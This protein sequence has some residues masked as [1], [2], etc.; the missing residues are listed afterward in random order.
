[1]LTNLSDLFC[2][3]DEI[4]W[5]SAPGW[6]RELLALGKRKH[7]HVY[8]TLCLDRGLFSSWSLLRS[9]LRELLNTLEALPQL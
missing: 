3:V 9:Y 1:M 7:Q 2:S 8:E 5:P 6:Q 4:F